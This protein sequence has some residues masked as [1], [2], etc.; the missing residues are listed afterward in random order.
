MVWSCLGDVAHPP[1]AARTVSLTVR[2]IDVLTMQPPT[3]LQ[4][5]ACSKLDVDCSHPLEA[6]SFLDQTGRLVAQLQAGFDG[7]LELRSSTT[8]PALFFVTLPLWQDTVI[9]STLPLVSAESFHGIAAALGATLDLERF[10]D[11]YALASDCA[12]APAAGVRFEVDR[13]N[14]R[15]KGYYMVNSVPVGSARATDAAGSGGFL[16]LSSGFT[17]ITGFVSSTGARVGESGFIVR[18]GAVSYPL[19]LPTE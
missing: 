18:T 4:V 10:G 11:V 15:T 19:I 8:L 14:E 9:Q 3:D 13:Q 16:N 17:S 12:G 7:Y 6:A 2:V 5:V 1:S